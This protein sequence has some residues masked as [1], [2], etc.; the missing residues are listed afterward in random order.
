MAK[1]RSHTSRAVEP[2][3]A[4]DLKF[5]NGIG[6]GVESRL[7]GVGIFT[8]AQLAALSPADV[9]AS[10]AGLAGLTAER[11]IKQD[12]LGQARELATKTSLTEPEWIDQARELAL[13][14]TPLASQ[15]GTEV[16]V[17]SQQVTTFTRE[18]LQESAQTE[19][20]HKDHATFT[21]AALIASETKPVTAHAAEV[22]V[23]TPQVATVDEPVAPI[24]VMTVPT[25]PAPATAEEGFTGVLHLHQIQMVSVTKNGRHSILRNEQPFEVHLNLDPTDQ[26]V[27]VDALLSYKASIYSKRIDGSPR[28]LIATAHGNFIPS[29]KI[30]IQ[31]EGVT[32][33]QGLYRLE[34]VVILTQ[35]SMKST[36]RPGFLA[37]AESGPLYFY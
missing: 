31:V 10:V 37:L 4:N 33:S 1:K 29:D 19:L 26:V 22:V 7:H 20:N 11:I 25:T 34:A 6:P 35:D 8:F 2:P 27:L 32:L 15:N 24:V 23:T 30:T 28:Q 9:A 14:S 21:S 13:T 18:E 36:S 3:E 16:R 17:D 12:W 5:I